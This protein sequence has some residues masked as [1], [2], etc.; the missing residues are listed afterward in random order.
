MLNCDVHHAPRQKFTETVGGTRTPRM[1]VSDSK[2][3][4]FFIEAASSSRAK[5]GAKLGAKPHQRLYSFLFKCTLSN[6]TL[7]RALPIAIRR[8]NTCIHLSS[9]IDKPVVQS[10]HVPH[11]L[12]WSS[13]WRV[14]HGAHPRNRFRASDRIRRPNH[15]SATAGCG[16]PFTKTCFS[17]RESTLPTPTF[18]HVALVQSPVSKMASR[19]S[20][21]LTPFTTAF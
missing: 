4:V 3:I 8:R 12:P 9:A 7:P 15:R 11:F 10:F 17:S 20:G 16:T 14:A 2:K 5:L 6:A 19:E 1:Y 21:T 18:R 13:E